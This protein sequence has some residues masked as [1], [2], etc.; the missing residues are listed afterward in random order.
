M[1]T[2]SNCTCCPVLCCRYTLDQQLKPSP[3]VPRPTKLKQSAMRNKQPEPPSPHSPLVHH[4]PSPSSMQ[5]SDPHPHPAHS[6]SRGRVSNTDAGGSASMQAFAP[7]PQQQRAGSASQQRYTPPPLQNAPRDAPGRTA[8]Q[9]NERFETLLAS[10]VQVETAACLRTPFFAARVKKD[11][12]ITCFQAAGG[13]F[14]QNAAN[15]NQNRHPPS[16][17]G[18]RRGQDDSSSGSVPPIAQTKSLLGTVPPIGQQKSTY[19][20]LPSFGKS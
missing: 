11:C 10:L 17:R 18:L 5:S 14:P 20:K 2:N 12:I 16:P 7:A 4:P 19:G 15:Q 9:V 1:N 3:P 8:K 13:M 6:A